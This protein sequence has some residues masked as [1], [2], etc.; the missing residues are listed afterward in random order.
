MSGFPARPGRTAFGPTFEDAEPVRNP[1]RNVGATL[2]NLMAWQLAGAGLVVPRAV[3]A[4]RVNG[5]AIA[6]TE[7]LLA[8]D[9]KRELA[10]VTTNYLGVGD[11][12]LDFASTYDDESG[13]ATPFDILRC[14][15]F[16]DTD[17]NVI[18]VAKR[19]N[20][21]QLRVRTFTSNTGAAV[22]VDFTALVY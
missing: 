10:D 7:Q 19:L 17:S 16:P 8:W 14:L 11:F 13:T 6:V 15:A 18:A 9:P 20:A 22:D 1:K 21:T 3:V 4:C 2:V 5:S 12:R